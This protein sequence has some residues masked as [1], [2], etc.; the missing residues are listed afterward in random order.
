MSYMTNFGVSFGTK[1]KFEQFFAEGGSFVDFK[2]HCDTL[3]TKEVLF[4]HKYFFWVDKK[5]HHVSYTENKEDI[6]EDLLWDFLGEHVVD[7]KQEVPKGD[8]KLQQ[9]KFS[10]E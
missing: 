3:P 2:A 10:I 1:H 9:T 6:H 4:A 7:K 5:L 8:H